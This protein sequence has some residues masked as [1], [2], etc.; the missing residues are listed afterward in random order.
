MGRDV[1][2]RIDCTRSDV[3]AA[4]ENAGRNSATAGQVPIVP[5]FISNRYTLAT[6]TF[7]IENQ[8]IATFSLACDGNMGDPQPSIAGI[9]E[10]QFR[11][12]VFT[13]PITLQPT[14][15]YAANEMAA[16]GV[17]DVDGVNK[18]AWGR[19][20]SVEV[21]LVARGLQASKL[22]D[23]AGAVA[24]FVNCAGTTVT[25]SDKLARRTYRK[26]F[27]MRNNLTQNIVPA[28]Q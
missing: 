27:A 17:V 15:F 26:I 1:G 16:L 19:V 24:P 28:A 20:V 3:G 5:L 18:D 23:T 4:T 11:Y 21:C 10:L 12:G 2:Q 22:T 25:P 13:D 7:S 6:T 9:E 14:R 8:S